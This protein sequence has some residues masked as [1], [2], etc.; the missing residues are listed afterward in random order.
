[1]GWDRPIIT[2]SGGFQ[3]F[4]LAHGGVADEIKGA[5]GRGEGRG[6]GEICER[7][8][9]F[10]ST[11]RR[12][13]PLPL[14]R[15]PRWRSRPSSAPTSPS[16]S[17]SARRSTPT[18]TTRPARPRGLTAGSTAA[19][20]GTSENGPERQALFGIVQ[21]GVHRGLRGESS[22]ASPPPRST[23]SRSAARSAATRTR[24][25]RA[26]DDHAP[27]A[28]DAAEH[29]LGIG[30]VDDLLLGSGSGSTSSTAP[31]RPGWRATGSPS[32]PSPARASASTC[33]KGGLG[34]HR[35][36][37]VEGCPCQACSRHGRA[38]ISYL[39]RAKEL[40]G[41]RLLDPPQPDLHG[42][43]DRGGARGDRGG[44]L[45]ALRRPGAR[46]AWLP[47]RPSDRD[48]AGARVT[49]VLIPSWNRA[50]RACARRCARFGERSGLAPCVIDT[51]PRTARGMVERLPRAPRLTRAGRQ[52]R[53]GA[54]I[55][56]AGRRRRP[57]SETG[58]HTTRCSTTTRRREFG[59]CRTIYGSPPWVSSSDAAPTARERRTMRCL[60]LRRPDG[61]TLSALAECSGLATGAGPAGPDRLAGLERAQPAPLLGGQSERR[62]IC[63]TARTRTR[64]APASYDASDPRWPG[65]FPQDGV[66]AS[67]RPLPR[68]A[69]R[70]AGGEG[71]F[72]AAAI[73][74]TRSPRMARRA[75]FEPCESCC[76]ANK[77]RR[78]PIWVDGVRLADG[79]S[80][81][82]ALALSSDRRHNRPAVSPR[83]PDRCGRTRSACVC[84]ELS[85]T[86]TRTGASRA[87]DFWT[88]RMGLF[89]LR[90]RRSPPGSPT[91]EVPAPA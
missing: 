83:L 9:A 13:R 23:G 57:A 37:L 26:R 84:R 63:P 43:P 15:G 38:Y 16:P 35:R 48:H 62:A 64:T 55:T 86:A 6:D 66:G 22:E 58:L 3:V 69:V 17:T 74:P 53:L 14:P 25:G 81:M 29:L 1:M 34:G 33:A 52:R 59:Y 20:S 47:G 42:A 73:H 21:G 31:C 77:A 79:R 72:D 91:P 60:V 19:S 80:R 75:R 36:P 67:A 18:A 68:A 49:V 40:T 44:R 28:A 82:G 30:E 5:G 87:P 4:S 89:D 76:A 10:Q 12:R 85:S 7:G 24:C 39:A 32:R 41:V 61:L 78:V 50:E 45:R 8:V 88:S 51:A 56:L 90:G 27:S 70:V 54:A 71:L 11:A 2:D 65:C 46:R